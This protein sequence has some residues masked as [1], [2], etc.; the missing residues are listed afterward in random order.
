MAKILLA[1]DSA[2]AQRMGAK[3]L[4]AEG[5]EVATVG[6]GQAAVKMLKE[7]I[8]D[9]IVAD[10]FM[11]GKNGYEL[12]E[13]IKKDPQ[14]SYIPVVLIVAPIEPYDA[15]EGKRV[16][17][18][19]LVT[20]PLEKSD[21]VA[22]V[23]KLLAL[24]KK[25]APAAKPPAP[26]PVAIEE[27]GPAVEEGFPTPTTTRLE[28]DIPEEVRQQ[29][30]SMMEDYL[31]SPVPPTEKVSFEAEPIP[32]GVSALE[33][34]SVEQPE[35]I[36]PEP[37]LPIRG[38]AQT[39]IEEPSAPESYLEGGLHASASV[40]EMETSPESEM[41]TATL[42]VRES[43]VAAPSS[44]TAEAVAVTE[45]DKKLFEPPPPDWQGLVSMVQEEEGATPFPTAATALGRTAPLPEVAQTTE[46]LAAS[47]PP[48]E[49]ELPSA[50]QPTQPQEHTAPAAV[51]EAM[52]SPPPEKQEVASMTDTITLLA[53]KIAPLDYA[54]VEQIVRETVEEM[55]PQIVDRIV[56]ATGITF[57]KKP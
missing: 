37:L 50:D 16:K 25:P 8:P 51:A 46:P 19:G 6:N 7:F 27:P 57:R 13:L 17:A 24:V 4:A 26:E 30:V 11:P 12:C 39:E 9:L 1:D 18:D 5:H 54:T 33:S 32:W 40:P 55:M 47:V 29:A 22:A 56:Q 49:T 23:Q 53:P 14:L 48:H 15:S 42:P 2:H 43:S 21:L 36:Q 41:L 10:V 35:E 31:E 44:W 20:K 28:F 34:V 38:I 3:I 45:E 52:V